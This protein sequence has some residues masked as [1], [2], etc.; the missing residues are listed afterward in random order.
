L[1]KELA[2][3][4]M[5]YLSRQRNLF[6][7]LTLTLSL[8]GAGL[9]LKLVT[10]DERVILVPG[11]SQEVWTNSGGVSKGYL[12][13]TTLMYLPLLLDLSSEVINHKAGLIFKYIS[14]DRPEYMKKIQEYFADAKE[15]YGKFSLS[16]YFSVKN[17]EVDSKGLI[18][19]ANGTLSCRYGERGFESMPASYRLSYEWIGG[20][21]RLKEFLKIKS[22]KE[23]KQEQGESFKNDLIDRTATEMSDD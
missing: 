11:L 15:K 7:I 9:T 20:R 12:E 22:D 18:V 4:N 19:I 23:K 17:L 2:I 8:I 10:S 1:E 16:T 5:E 13:E 21:L 6:L 3:H 14:Q